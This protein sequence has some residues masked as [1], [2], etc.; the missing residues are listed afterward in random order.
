[1]PGSE[2]LSN[3]SGGKS[4]VA[5]SAMVC[6]LIHQ[7]TIQQKIWGLDLCRMCILRSGRMMIGTM[8]SWAGLNCGHVC[9][10][11][12]SRSLR[13]QQTH[14]NNA[15]ILDVLAM[16]PVTVEKHL[17]SRMVWHELVSNGV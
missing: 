7:W 1:M 12:W 17:Q 13:S 11:I 15:C 16:H 4:T 10:L 8:D 6:N 14:V 2:V 3:R 9:L 5:E